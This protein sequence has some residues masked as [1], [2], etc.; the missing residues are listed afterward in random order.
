MLAGMVGLM[1]FGFYKV[2]VGIREHKYVSPSHQLPTLH[3]PIAGCGIHKAR[4]GLGLLPGHWLIYW[5]G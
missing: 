3:H 5:C 1:T 4:E 2:G